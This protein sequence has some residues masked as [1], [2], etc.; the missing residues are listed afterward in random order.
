MSHDNLKKIA[1]NAT[2]SLAIDRSGQLFSWGT[3]QF[4]LT[5]FL[6]R[7]GRPLVEEHGHAHAIDQPQRVYI[8]KDLVADAKELAKNAAAVGEYITEAD[9]FNLLGG[10]PSR[11]TVLQQCSAKHVSLGTY[12]GGVVCNDVDTD[13]EFKPLGSNCREILM[14]MREHLVG[15]WDRLSGGGPQD[16]GSQAPKEVKAELELI[17]DAYY[18]RVQIINGMNREQHDRDKS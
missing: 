11:Q 8:K 16:G 14:E 5:T 18:E 6:D 13:Y 10:K 9:V 4:G 1:A 17:A 12:H 2:N 3:T 7:H 15:E